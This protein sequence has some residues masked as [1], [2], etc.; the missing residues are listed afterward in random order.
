MEGEERLRVARMIRRVME[1]RG[2]TAIVV[3][4]DI[5]FA[6]YISDRLAIFGGE[7]GV[8]GEATEPM[9]MRDGMNLFLRGLGITLR[10]DPETPHPS[11]WTTTCPLASWRSS[12]P[13]RHAK[14][15]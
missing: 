4:H 6:D 14:R 10:R 11:S 15:T 1:K 8:R 12:L 9:G 5:L 2:T 3:D 13:H 7:P